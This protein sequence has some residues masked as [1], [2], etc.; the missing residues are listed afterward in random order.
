MP[1]ITVDVQA[2]DITARGMRSLVFTTSLIGYFFFID[3]DNDFKYAK[4]TDGGATWGGLTTIYTG[5]VLA[6]D[7]WFEPWTPGDSGTLI[8]AWYI[9]SNTDDVRYRTLDTN[10]DSL[11]T[12]RVV[13]AGVSAESRLACF[14]SG[15]K[16][17]GGNLLVAFDIDGGTEMGTYRSTDGGATWGVRT[18]LVEALDDRLLMFPGNEAD[19]QDMWAVYL[20][21]STPNSVTL[22]VHDDSANTNSESATIFTGV[23]S[24]TDLTAQQPCAG[25]IRHSDGHLLMVGWTEYDS[26]TGVF[27]VFDINGTGSITE[28]TALATNIDDCYY[29]SVYVAGNDDIYIAYI[30]K[31]DGSENLSTATGVYYVTSTDGGVTWS[32]GDTTYSVG[33]LDWRQTWCALNGPRFMVAWRDQGSDELLTN[34]DNS[35]VPL[36][37]APMPPLLGPRVNVLLRL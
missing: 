5:T 21:V 22:K 11:G 20:D 25:A 30:G 29:P 27:R 23:F 17:R 14:V 4:T 9:E 13:F 1:D 37:P 15:A 32:A 7:V 10:G 6:Y 16:A 28:K 18:N 26:A 33:V 12:E 3:F 36:I 19:S 31:R 35:V 24:I 8:H 2:R 34:F